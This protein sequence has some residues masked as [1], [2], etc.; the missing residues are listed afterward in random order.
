MN[1]LFESPLGA[2]LAR[3]WVDPV[4]LFGLRRWYMPLSRLC[5]AANAADGDAAR[6]RDEIGSPLPAAWPETLINGLLARH[7]KARSAADAARQAWEKAIFSGRD[8]DAAALDRR[9]RATATRHLATRAFFYPL[10][11][12]CRPAAAR[13]RI[14]SPEE[15]ERTLGPLIENPVAL[16]GVPLETGTV[17]VSR[18]FSRN[19]LK[20]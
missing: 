5:A 7:D 16:Y 18:S 10:L 20:E 6:F 12:P 4:G 2:V 8:V 13:W 14:E 3:P 11:F 9:R 17:S 1:V 15:V 19:G